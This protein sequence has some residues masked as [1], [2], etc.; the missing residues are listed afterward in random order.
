MYG[1]DVIRRSSKGHVMYRALVN[2]IMW[3]CT[4]FVLSHGSRKRRRS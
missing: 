2:V 1:D 3:L 4:L